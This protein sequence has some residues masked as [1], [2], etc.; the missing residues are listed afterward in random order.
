MSKL[1]KL[2]DTNEDWY[3]CY[4]YSLHHSVGHFFSYKHKKLSS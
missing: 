2:A 1:D 3:E 4:G